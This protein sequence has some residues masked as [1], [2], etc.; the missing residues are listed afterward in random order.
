[1]YNFSKNEQRYSEIILFLNMVSKIKKLFQNKSLLKSI[2]ALWVCLVV[3]GGWLGSMKIL[4]G[5]L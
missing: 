5:G 3:G 1:M 4:T 2:Q